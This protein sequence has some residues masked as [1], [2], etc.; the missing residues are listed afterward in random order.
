MYLDGQSSHPILQILSVSKSPTQFCFLFSLCDNF[1]CPAVFFAGRGCHSMSCF[2]NVFYLFIF[3]HLKLIFVLYLGLFT[4]VSFLP[5]LFC[6]FFS[7]S[8]SLCFIC[9]QSLHILFSCLSSFLFNRNA[10][11]LAQLLQSCLT[12]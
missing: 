5:C 11:I 9:L 10:C 6:H 2:E 4:V 12:L 7:P 8:V 3:Y 1:F